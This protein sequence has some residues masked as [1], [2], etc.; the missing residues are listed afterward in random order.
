M[1][2]RKVKR[3]IDASQALAALF[4]RDACRVIAEG[5]DNMDLLPY[6]DEL[7]VKIVRE[8]DEALLAITEPEYSDEEAEVRR[9]YEQAMKEMRG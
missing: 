2:D 4:T 1:T 6:L 7:P 8:F 5:S 9:K 3:L